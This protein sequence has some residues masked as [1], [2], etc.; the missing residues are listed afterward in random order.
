MFT[1]KQPNLYNVI[2]PILRLL[3]QSLLKYHYNFSPNFSKIKS[4]IN[5][6]ELKNHV[7]NI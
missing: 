3:I 2:K 6:K 5:D 4:T 1:K 7:Y